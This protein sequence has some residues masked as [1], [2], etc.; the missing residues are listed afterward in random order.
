MVPQKAPILLLEAFRLAAARDPELTLDYVGGGPL[1]DAAAM[2]VRACELE[3]RVKI[4]GIVS[5]EEK[6][7]LI[8]ACGVFVQHSVTVPVTGHE[9]GLPAA[10][11]EAMA[12]GMAVVSTRHS[13]IVEAVIEGETGLLVEEGDVKGMAEAFLRVSPL[14][15]ALGQA[16]YRKAAANYGWQH[17]KARIEQHLSAAVA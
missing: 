2:F 12:H 4:H 9:E 3:H 1:V 6:Y 16:G 7:R 11:Q 5:E 14:A 13:G 15:E 8:R 17:E 10:I